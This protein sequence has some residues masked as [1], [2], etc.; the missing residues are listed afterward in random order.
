[1]SA[2]STEGMHLFS[3]PEMTLMQK[4]LG[5][6]PINYVTHLKQLA[7]SRAKSA[8]FHSANQSTVSDGT[9]ASTTPLKASVDPT[10]PAEISITL[11]QA[12]SSPNRVNAN[13]AALLDGLGA[14]LGNM[15]SHTSSVTSSTLQSPPIPAGIHRNGTSKVQHSSYSPS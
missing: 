15:R 1:M 14:P 9:T 7:R 2:N 4:P 10:V 3:L 6:P 13:G 11:P 12:T 5:P 8:P